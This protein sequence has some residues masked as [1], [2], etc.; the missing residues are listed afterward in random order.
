MTSKGSVFN[1]LPSSYDIL[2]K[3]CLPNWQAFFSTI[4]EFIPES[5]PESVHEKTEGK[6]ERQNQ[7]IEIL[8]LGSGTG[9]F[10]S[11]IRKE[12]PDARITCIDRNPEMLAVAK[13]K[14]ELQ[15]NVTF[16]EGD[17]LEECEKWKEETG[18]HEEPGGKEGPEGEGKFDV[19]V[20]TQ[21]LCFLPQDAKTRV[22]RRIYE[23]LKPDGSFIEGDIFR[24]GSE[25][26]EEIYRAHWKKYMVEQELTVQEAEEMLQTFDDIQEKI[27]T[28]KRFRERMEEAGFERIFCPYWYEMYA[29]FVARR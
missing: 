9:F 6:N 20:S 7:K 25:W 14:P 8:E 23:A 27:D 19:V 11:L 21:C 29:V 10:T 18:R 3:Q 13:E 1:D 12:R 2:Q 28:H 16:I 17:I 24:P 26:K 5:I 22:F 15:K 4:I